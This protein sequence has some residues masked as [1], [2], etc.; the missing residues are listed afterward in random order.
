MNPKEILQ[1]IEELRSMFMYG[2]RFKAV[3]ALVCSLP[4]KELMEYV[5]THGFSPIDMKI[6]S[7]RKLEKQFLARQRSAVNRIIAQLEDPECTNLTRLREGLK[8]RYD[9]V[10]IA[11][12]H[13]I[14]H[15]M[16]LQN[17]KKERLWAFTRLCKLWDANFEED[18]LHL[19]DEY[20]EV[21]CAH[22]IIRQFPAEYVYIHREELAAMAGWQWV[23]E[24]LGRDY[25]DVL[26]RTK[27][28]PK[29]WVRTI[30]HLNLNEYCSNI[31]D[32]LYKTIATTVDAM[33]WGT[34]Y[35]C[36]KSL[37]DMPDVG[38]AVWAMG[39]MGM[40]ESVLRFADYDRQLERFTISDDGSDGNAKEEYLWLCQ[41][42]DVIAVGVLG[43][44]S[45]VE[46]GYLLAQSV[47]QDV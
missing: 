19:F 2:G 9:H 23:M 24:R 47:S 22:V 16:L 7:R 17:T 39:Q 18:V 10:P 1:H 4:D 15:C 14:L 43:W 35:Y 26:D 6:I 42:Y 36:P 46:Q 11:Y 44:P 12:Q 8:S 41:V 45:R 32:Y 21:E 40:T 3:Y 37:R 30:V 38:Y 20:R 34:R 28:L 29:D 31:E 5:E 25:P 13:R 27:L 33:L